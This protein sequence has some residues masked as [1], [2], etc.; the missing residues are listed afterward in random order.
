M[1]HTK[2]PWKVSDNVT[3]HNDTFRHGII[4]SER[5]IAWTLRHFDRDP[6]NCKVTDQDDG[7]ARLIAAAPDL[8]GALRLAIQALKNVR[9]NGETAYLPIIKQGE[10]AICKAEGRDEG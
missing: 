8:L 10:E 9:A 1:K 2:G 3:K 6:S 5:V 4:A 7:D